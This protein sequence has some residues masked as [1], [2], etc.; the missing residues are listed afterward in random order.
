MSVRQFR[1]A[2]NVAES[3]SQEAFLTETEPEIQLILAN[4]VLSL[5]RATFVPS[6]NCPLVPSINRIQIW[7]SRFS[8]N[9]FAGQESS[10]S[11]VREFK[12]SLTIATH[13][14][15]TWDF[16]V[17]LFRNDELHFGGESSVGSVYNNNT[18]GKTAC[19]LSSTGHVLS[20]LTHELGHAFGAL[21]THD[22]ISG[23]CGDSRDGSS[24]VEIGSGITIMSYAGS[25]EAYDNYATYAQ[26]YP[27]FHA[28]STQ[29]ILAYLS[30][31]T[32]PMTRSRTPTSRL[33]PSP[34]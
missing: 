28:R 34:G 6:T 7:D 17:A 24:A 4:A 26:R 19:N 12:Y 5:N 18:K 21:H 22:A 11:A 29:D 32:E 30:T 31:V 27:R 15:T 1:I 16:S 3:F 10:Y 14:L 23:L 33:R 25:G 13:G 2:I 9:A 20:V 8:S